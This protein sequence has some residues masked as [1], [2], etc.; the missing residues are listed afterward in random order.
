MVNI[1]GWGMFWLG[2][3]GVMVVEEIASLLKTIVRVHTVKKTIKEILKANPDAL[4]N[5]KINL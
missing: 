3:F 2:L 5:F 1:T 4:E